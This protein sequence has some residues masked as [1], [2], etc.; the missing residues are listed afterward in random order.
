MKT[1]LFLRHGKS[2]WSHPEL[3]DSD[4]P[5]K[6]R[7]RRDAPLMG[8][9]LKRFDLVPEIVFSSPALRAKQ[10][11][12]LAAENWGNAFSIKWVDSFYPGGFEDYLQTI[13]TVSHKCDRIMIVGHNPAIEDTVRTLLGGRL[14]IRFPTA[15]LVC[16]E[17]A[18]SAWSDI[19]P[20]E[21][22][23]HW[24][25]IPRLVSAIV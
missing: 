14:L 8:N 4:R 18:V 5:L 7:G 15:G 12:E 21:C 17:S 25:I 1:I 13:A 9:V 19:Q 24:F 11:V 20:G 2:D 3:R 16:L 10:T 6:K 23:L 22:A